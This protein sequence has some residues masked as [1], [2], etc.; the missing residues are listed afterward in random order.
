MSFY[1]KNILMTCKME[2]EIAII[3]LIYIEKLMLL[4][5]DVSLTPSNWRKIAFTSLV[6]GSKIWDDES[7]ENHNFAKVSNLLCFLEFGVRGKSKPP[8][9]HSHRESSKQLFPTGF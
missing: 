6:L 7:F 8:E 9:C 4:N 5:P 2:K 1:C 3:C